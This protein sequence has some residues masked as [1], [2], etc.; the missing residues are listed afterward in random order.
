MTRCHHCRQEIA[1][2]AASWVIEAGRRKGRTYCSRECVAAE[3]TAEGEEWP[4]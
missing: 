4:S 3:D 1:R 2:T